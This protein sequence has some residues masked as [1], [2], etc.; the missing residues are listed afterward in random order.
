MFQQFY[1]DTLASRLIKTLLSSTPLPV[2]SSVTEGD[3]IVEDC[4]YTCGTSIILCVHTGILTMSAPIVSTLY[5]SDTLYPSE[6]LYPGSGT[7][8][9]VFKVIDH[10]DTSDPRCFTTFR[11]SHNYYDPDTH[12]YLGKYLRYIR[13]STG[14]NLLPYYNCF[15]G[16]YFSDALLKVK[17]NS[18]VLQ[19]GTSDIHKVIA[20]PIQFGHTYTV[21]INCPEQLL[22]RA[23]VHL[24]SGIVKEDKSDF[25]PQEVIDALVASGARY[26]GCSFRK[27]FSFRVDCAHKQ[28]AS[29]EKYLYLLIQVPQ[30]N[31]SAVTVLDNVTLEQGVVCDENSVRKYSLSRLSLLQMDGAES[32]AFSDRLIEYLLNNV[33]WAGDT[34]FRNI[35]NVQEALMAQFND[36]KNL[37]KQNRATLGI[38]DANIS[39]YIMSIVEE[40]RTNVALVDQD[41][42]VN[43]DIESFIY[44][45]GGQN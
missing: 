4:Y 38:W 14:L 12:I 21:A 42:H 28:A 37:I 39:N 23:C 6:F 20:V 1:T 19:R 29:L 27:P 3:C 9:G 40:N 5:P 7:A 17:D 8:V 33:I 15:A 44:A 30:S 32:Y 31:N 13:T 25:L 22:L 18:V 43:K 34:S 35:A 10:I 26:T 16:K 11:S 24:D 36:Y 45:T 41:G 2:F